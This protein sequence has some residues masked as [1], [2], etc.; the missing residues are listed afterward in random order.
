MALAA[1]DADDRVQQ[2]LVLTDRLTDLLAAETR[3]FEAR[4]PQ[5]AAA[6]S[7][8][9]QRLANLYRHEAARI[10]AE[11][12][13]IAS[14]RPE[15]RRALIASTRGFEAVVARHGRALQAAKMI[16]EGLVQAI[17][18]EVAASRAPAAYG[19]GARM[20]QADGT[21]ITLNRRA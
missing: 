11:P 5:D 14:A 19:P 3:A 2:L 1:N 16:T 17:A 15:S 12:A 9:T 10:R 21:S 8:E 18:A 7:E 4:R 6:T 20:S 13:L